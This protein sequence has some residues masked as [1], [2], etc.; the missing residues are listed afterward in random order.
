MNTK[1][2]QVELLNK[3]KLIDTDIEKS[4][5]ELEKQIDSMSS[6]ADKLDYFVAI[7]SG[8]LSGAID[9]LWVSGFDLHEGREIADD[10]A[11]DFVVQVAKFL[12]YEGDDTTG[13]VKFLEEKF[14]IP[15]DGN[16]PDF[17]GGLQHHLRDF[18]HH[19]TLVGLICSLLTQFTLKSYGTDVNGNFK[20]VPVPEKSLAFIGENVPDKIWKGTIIWFFH[21]VSDFVG[22]GSTAG[23]GGGTGIPGPILS[24]AKELSVLPMFKNLQIGDNSLSKFLSKLFNGTLFAQRDENGKIIKDSILK[25]DLRGELGVGIELGK[26]AV[27]VLA[28]DCMV[29]SFYFL[30]R[31][32]EEM[33][34]HQIQ[35]LSDFSLISWDKIKPWNDP[36]LTRMLTVATAVF[37]TI[38]V[39]EAIIT[40]KYW[41]SVNYVGIGRFTLAMGSETINFLRVRDI[42]KLKAMYEKVERNVF[43]EKDNNIYGRLGDEVIDKFALTLEQTELL[44]NLELQKTLN[45]IEKC[46]DPDIKKLK[47]QW[48]SEW[49]RYIGLGF[50]GFTNVE[51]AEIHWY[52]SSELR[53]KFGDQLNT[54]WFKLIILESMLFQPYFPLTTEE[55]EDGKPVPSKRYNKLNSKRHRC[56]K[57]QG[58]LFLDSFFNQNH[59]PTNLAKRFRKTYKEVLKELNEVLKS[60]LKGLGVM[61]MVTVIVVASAG[62]FAPKIAVILVGS[63]FA[64]LSGAALTSACLA[65][66]GGG[67]VAIGG[68]GMAGGT[69]VIVGGGAVLGASLGA[70]AGGIV[71]ATSIIN[72][73]Q[74]ILQ[75]AKLLV[76]FREIFLNDEHDIA[77][78]NSIYEQYVK[79]IIELEKNL[80]KLKIEADDTNDKEERKKL[81]AEAQELEKSIKA[82]K[83]ARKNMNRFKSSFVE[84][85]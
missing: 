82:M 54:V 80:A 19:P 35:N 13:A 17:G 49:K 57:N 31:L 16:T 25:F 74:T 32:V 21:L 50:A 44:Y 5:Y 59:Y 51:G 15:S 70:G 30:R 67:A 75:S 40:Q 77:Y 46:S 20:V 4:I 7:S 42:K 8:I 14:K 36:T 22:S 29:R 26:Q 12:G 63:K 68:A 43:N 66:L 81:K 72:E 79:T 38:D 2:I 37:T 83:I 27:P 39:S 48:S 1:E 78:S 53:A 10:K 18:A 45:D 64:G 55:D 33:K 85:L 6:Q 84:G 65:Y 58:D 11:Q 34:I 23:K 52:S 56:S 71:M 3:E 73:E 61:A 24:L 47:V 69:L 76:S 9:I 60:R 62:A 28:N 41:V